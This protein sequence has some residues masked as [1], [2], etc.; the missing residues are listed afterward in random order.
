[1]KKYYFLI[2]LIYCFSACDSSEKNTPEAPLASTSLDNPPE[3]AK[4]VI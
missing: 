2:S 1:M 3:W 4:D